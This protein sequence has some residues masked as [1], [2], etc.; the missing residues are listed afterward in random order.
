AYPCGVEPRNAKNRMRGR[1]HSDQYAVRVRRKDDTV[2]WLEIGGAPVFDPNGRVVGSIGVHNDITER[3]MAEQALRESEARY[4]LMAEHSTDPI[5]R[6][7]PA[8]VL[9]YA[10]DASRRLLGYEPTELVG[11]SIYE[12]IDQQDAEEVR[13]LAKLIHA[14]HSMTFSYRVR[15]KDGTLTWFETMSR[16]VTDHVTGRTVEIVSGARD[17]SERQQVEDEI[18]HAAYHDGRT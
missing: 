6:S 8:G 5:S 11:H 15:R 14:S 3:R 13:Q 10:S 2:I 7:T 16:A 4:R 9:I 18:E 1:G 12:Y 17:V